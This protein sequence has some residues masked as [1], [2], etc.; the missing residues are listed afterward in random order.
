V[1]QPEMMTTSSKAAIDHAPAKIRNLIID[2][3]NSENDELLWHAEM[4]DRY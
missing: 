3:P 2:A 1:R 4:I